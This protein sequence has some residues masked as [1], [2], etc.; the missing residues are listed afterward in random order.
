MSAV[1]PAR[2]R[3]GAAALVLPV[4]AALAGFLTTVAIFYPGVLSN[5]AVGLYSNLVTG[6]RNDAK[7]RLFVDLWLL[8]DAV[9]CGSGGIFV[10]HVALHWSAALALATALTSNALPRLALVLGLGFLPPTFGRLPMVSTDNAVLAAWSL[11]VGLL[12]HRDLRAAV[13]GRRDALS[14]GAGALLAYGALVRHNAITGVVP[15]L[16]L[17]ASPPEPGR[18]R[19][20]RRSVALTAILALLLAVGAQA[21]NRTTT[22][23][24]PWAVTALWDLAAMSVRS[25]EVLVPRSSMR[26]PS[27]EDPLP[28]LERQYSPYSAARLVFP[29]DACLR[30]P[31]DS[32][33]ARGLLGTWRSA[34]VAHPREYLWHRARMA[35]LL[36][37]LAD[38]PIGV[39]FLADPPQ[40]A[41]MDQCEGP[42]RTR[43]EA[44]PA[45]R[46]IRAALRSLQGTPVYWTWLWSLA[47]VAS[48]VAGARLGG[49]RG[50]F[51]CAVAASGI[52][53]VAPVLFAAPSAEFRYTLWLHAATAI[54]IVLLATALFELRRERRSVAD[55]PRS[56]GP[57]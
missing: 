52:C 17:L 36:M 53:Q 56:N 12:L 24:Y 2:R 18:G 13:G 7:P 54:A 41:R 40:S 28:D 37:A 16:W 22:R 51:A 43:F 50:R 46:S 35:A 27:A 5:D 6:H 19:A 29:D 14:I 8:T 4:V 49:T 45:S 38:S 32:V 48:V 26:D 1:S 20:R 23:I 39:L 15:L 57:R 9:V 42:W 30:I 3:R 10:L 47:C 44:S 34:I 31:T 55:A 21:M 33:Q 11:G 25:G